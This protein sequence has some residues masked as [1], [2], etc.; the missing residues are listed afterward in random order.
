MSSKV[1]TVELRRIFPITGFICYEGPATAH[2]WYANDIGLIGGREQEA[3]AEINRAHQLDPLSPI[4]SK[5]AGDI[6]VMAR[7][8]D[9]ALV[10]CK[11]LADEEPTFSSVHYCLYRAYWGKRMYPQVIEELKALGQLSGDRNRSEFASAMGQGFRSA[12]WKGALAKGIETLQAQ[13]KT[14]SSSA[15]LIAELYAQLGDKDH[16]F[17]WL[18]TACQER[19]NGAIDTMQLAS[20]SLYT[21]TYGIDGEGRWNAL[22]EG[23]TTVVPTSGATYN[24]ASQPLTIPVGT[25]AGQGDNYTYDSNTGRMTHWGYEVGSAAETGTLTWNDNWT[26]ES[27]AIVDGV[28]AGGTQT[29][30]YNSSLVPGTGYDDLGRLIGGSCGSSGSLWNQTDIYDQ[31]DNLTKSSTGFVSWNPG[32]S[33]TTNHYTC[34]G[35]TY[36]SSG[37]VTNDGTNAYTWNGYTKMASVNNTSGTGCGS[38]GCLV[39]DALGRVVEID[40]S[41]TPVEIWYTQLG[42]TAYMNGTT[43]NYAYWP[44]PGDATALYN[45]SVYFM[46]KDWLGNA[47]IISLVGSSPSVTSDRA[48]APYGE[49]YDIFGSTNQNEAMFTGDTQDV[50][51]GMYDTPNRELQA[52]SQGRWLSPDPAGAGWNQYAYPTDPNDNVDPS[53]LACYPIE[54][55]RHICGFQGGA[56][57]FGWNWDQFGLFGIDLTMW[58]L[59]EG[60]VERFIVG[61]GFV[62][63]DSGSPAAGN[64]SGNQPPWKACQ[65]GTQWLCMKVYGR[66]WLQN[67]MQADQQIFNMTNDPYLWASGGSVG[68]TFGQI[69]QLEQ[70]NLVIDNV[71]LGNMA[72]SALDN[73]QGA[74]LPPG[75]TDATD[76]G[77]DYFQE[78]R[79]QNNAQIDQMVQA[80]LAS[81]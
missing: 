16:A 59:R 51:T 9:E 18:N 44:A 45:G 50:L 81:W 20:P 24:A 58:G 27:V 80:L 34:T 78:V 12:G 52:S 65:W 11:K 54:I 3:L 72:M 2:Q 37:N 36:D 39:Y 74:E 13:S 57:Q 69:N 10:G 1:Q 38:A 79:N 46:H 77:I 47:R 14:G 71:A 23:S 42:K 30:S 53:G 26:L 32:Y 19:N 62:F 48:I 66:V 70:V 67:N 35:C 17:Q 8:Y 64:Q 75:I 41:S 6:Q 4:I 29:C 40:G 21:L 49:I 76:A 43:E 15:Y 5:Q 33:P 61:N 25:G 55:Q 63:G 60:S 22:S 31:Y 56:G 7:Q 28:N 73:V 68:A